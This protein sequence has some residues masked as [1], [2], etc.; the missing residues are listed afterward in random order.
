MKNSSDCQKDQPD[1]EFIAHEFDLVDKVANK[2]CKFGLMEG[3]TAMLATRM[4]HCGKVVM[5]GA[6]AITGGVSFILPRGSKD[7][8][9]LTNGTLR[10][11]QEG[12]LATLE[13]FYDLNAACPSVSDAKITFTK[14]RVFFYA[15]F[16]ACALVFLEMIFDRQKP[17]PQEADLESSAPAAQY[18]DHNRSLASAQVGHDSPEISVPSTLPYP[19]IQKPPAGYP[20]GSSSMSIPDR[21]SPVT[22]F[23]SPIQTQETVLAADSLPEPI[24]KDTLDAD[25][26]EGGDRRRNGERVTNISNRFIEV[27]RKYLYF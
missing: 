17:S 2:S 4:R 10:L 23:T 3:A 16:V 15:T 21:I 19:P 14:L 7:T 1:P 25:E 6:P 13:S 11:R 9:A 20:I 27:L 12:K 18:D 5:T 8:L 26:E 22:T 24:L